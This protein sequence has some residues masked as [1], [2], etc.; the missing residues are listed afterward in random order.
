MT[1]S[2]LTASEKQHLRLLAKKSIDEGVL[3]QRPAKAT[4]DDYFGTLGKPGASFV[5]L[6]KNHEL[7]GCI[8]SLQAHRRLA[9]DV[10]DNAYHA[11]FKDYRFPPLKAKELNSL[12]IKISVL[13]PEEAIIFTSESDLLAQIRP[14]LDG[15]VLTDGMNRG[16]FLPSVWEQ[17]PDVESFW[18]HLKRKAGLSPD[19]WSPSL[20][21]TRYTTEEF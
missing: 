5:T 21:V 1:S 6:R 4:S 13:S 14:G 11:A 3:S 12:E 20:S 10:L 8:G 16:T 18:S 15:L 17:L 19:H 2:S 9:D 7:R